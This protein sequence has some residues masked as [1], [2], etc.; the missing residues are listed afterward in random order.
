MRA[1]GLPGSALLV[2]L[3]LLSG[4]AEARVV[5]LI[6][7]LDNSGSMTAEADQVQASLNS[8]ASGLQASGHD[9]HVIAISAD[10]S[11]EQ[12]L[13]APAPLGSGS[14]PSDQNLAGY[15]HVVQ[16]VG[17][18]NALSLVLSTY[19]TYASSL[20]AG[21][22]RH[23]V[24]ITDDESSLSGASFTSQLLALDADFADF[25]F[26]AIAAQT[27]DPLPNPPI[28]PFP[29]CV[30][31]ATTVG[32]TY[33]DLADARGGIFE[34]L[35]DEQVGISLAIIAQGI[36]SA[37]VPSLARWPARAALAVLLLLPL[38]ALARRGRRVRA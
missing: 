1:R 25:R 26:H 6:V 14:C 21:S 30:V 13:C 11:D 2:G 8:L 28:P 29:R 5:D 35:C 4:P 23:I 37:P 32:Q 9:L 36:T 10:S 22:E 19:P 15:R 20:R 24:V 7:V 34:D 12:G 17:S 31:T 16:A 27:L 18:T 3:V 33:I 38:I